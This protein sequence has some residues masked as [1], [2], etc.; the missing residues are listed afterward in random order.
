M[1]FA[2]SG[3]DFISAHQ[4]RERADGR[5]AQAVSRLSRADTLS[6]AFNAPLDAAGV[7]HKLGS[8]MPNN[9]CCVG[10]LVR[11]GLNVAEGIR[12]SSNTCGC[13]FNTLGYFACR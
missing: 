7:G 2:L 6:E 10:R 13:G 12:D 8:R 3:R 4:V 9:S 5:H 11:H 1:I